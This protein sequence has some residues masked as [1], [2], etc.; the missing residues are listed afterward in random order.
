VK[1]IKANTDLKG[2]FLNHEKLVNSQKLE[3]KALFLHLKQD[4]IV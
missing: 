3:K 4:N 2:L 1:K